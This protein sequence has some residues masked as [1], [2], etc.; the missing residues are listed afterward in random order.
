MTENT[1]KLFTPIQARSVTLHSRI[2]VSPMCMYSAKDGLANDFHQSHYGSFAIKGPGLIFLEATAVEAR[3]RSTDLDLG[4][5]S[6]DHI[7]PIKRI[8]DFIKSQGSVPGLQLGHAG[9]KSSMSAIGPYHLLSE[10]EGGW[11]D[12][13]V[14][15]SDIPFD[16][17]H[18]RPRPLTVSEIKQVVQSWADAAIRA[19]K[20]GVEVLEIH[21]AHGYLLHNFLSG[22]S[23]KRTDEYGGSLEN[24]LR[25]PLEVVKAV[26]QVW[27]EHKPL[28][29]RLS[30]TDFKNPET[31]GYDHEG[32]DIHQS[33]VY[34]SALKS[35]GVDVIDVSSGGNLHVKYPV[36]PSYQ[37]PLAAFIR[38]EVGIATGTV[39]VITE[40]QQAE[41]ILQDQ[42]ADYILIARE[43]LRNSAWTHRAAYELGVDVQ[44]SRQYTRAKHT[45]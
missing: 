26:R 31:L 20:A 24:R 37:V 11:P 1:P 9:R 14:G 42:K 23:N 4:I 12:Q 22:N 39:G 10:S 15:P 43:F 38:K 30:G 33:T 17:R 21:S 19:D 35:L 7:A 32:W 45:L 16:D 41:H 25:F 27:P 44:W 6:D 5:W 3:G 29:V 28:W 36:A 13:V 2:V 40:P 18:G 8:T 34:A